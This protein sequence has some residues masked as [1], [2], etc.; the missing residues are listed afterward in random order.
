[1]DDDVLIYDILIKGPNSQYAQSLRYIH[2]FS[3]PPTPLLLA[4]RALRAIRRGL[5]WLAVARRGSSWLAIVRLC[6]APASRGKP[7]K[8]CLLRARCARFA[9]ARHC[10]PWLAIVRQ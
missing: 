3:S 2:S 10:S 9:V 1:M 7:W 4:S 6:L 5:P 8:A